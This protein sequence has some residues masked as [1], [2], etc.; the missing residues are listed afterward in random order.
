[1]NNPKVLLILSLFNGEKYL[2]EQIDSILCQEG[3][4]VYFSIRDDGSTDNSWSIINDY[5]SKYPDKFIILIRGDNIGPLKSIEELLS[6]ASN[7]EF[8]YYAF[9]DQDDYW[10]PQKLIKGVNAI[11]KMKADKPRFYFSNLT[12]TDKD[13]NPRFNAYGKR[14]VTPTPSACFVDFRASGNTYIMDRKALDLI[15]ESNPP[16]H[17][18]ADVL[19]CFLCIFMGNVK[20]DETPYILFRR[21]GENA[22]GKR[23]KGLKLTWMRLKKLRN[24]LAYEDDAMRMEMAKHMLLLYRNQLDKEKIDILETIA[25]YQK[26]F[27]VK[28]KLIFSPKIKSRSLSRNFHMAVRVILNQF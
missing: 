4:D 2:R 10:L 21:T 3:V 20:Y 13:L 27:A 12:I 25:N 11:D 23:E 28:L 8:D 16:E 26:S 14:D 18:Y 19:Y 24:L 22:S 17:I 15:S 5:K 9:S 6:Q 1:M 7:T